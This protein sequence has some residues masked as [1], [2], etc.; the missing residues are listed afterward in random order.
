MKQYI[1]KIRPYFGH[2]IENLRASGEWKIHLTLKINFSQQK[3]VAK[4]KLCI[5]E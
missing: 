1:E 5:L 4:V 2:M 3:T